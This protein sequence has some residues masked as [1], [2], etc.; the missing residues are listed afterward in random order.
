VRKSVFYPG[1][2]FF[3]PLL[4]VVLILFTQCTVVTHV[5]RLSRFQNSRYT[6]AEE[7]VQGRLEYI[8]SYPVVHIYGTPEEMGRQYG[9]LLKPQLQSL[10][11]LVE[12]VFSEEELE[13]YLQLA[14]ATEP[15]LPEE[16]RTEIRA[17]AHV[18]GISYNHLVA[19]NVATKVACSTLAT[20]GESTPEGHLIMGRNA[21]YRSKGMNKYLGLLVV[22]HP[23]NGFKSIHIT[24]LGLVGG[25]SGMNSTGL[26]YGN[27]IS[28]NSKDD[29]VNIQGLPVQLAMRLAGETTSTADE[30]AAF[31]L[32]RNLMVPNIVMVADAEKAVITEH[33]PF[34]GERREG[35]KGTL[36]S[37]NFFHTK[38]LS[39]EYKPDKRYSILQ[40]EVN[41]HYGN[42]T[43]DRMKSVMY[44]I[45]GRKRRNLQ[46][47]IME[48]S[49]M[50]L[51]ISINKIPASK[52]P[53]KEFDA[54][55]LFRD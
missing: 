14:A 42:F 47:V 31:M 28:Y 8:A 40:N 46:C 21:D 17:I 52:G 18:S 49:R 24:Y 35:E 16:I 26:S 54:M 6:P 33:T 15:F 10:F 41:T 5:T 39:V 45:R 44:E 7:T 36:G 55:E 11:T 27:M 29:S 51:H 9:F 12:S 37:T 22:R 19:L 3:I 53:F 32:E 1:G 13:E 30:Y 48:P 23:E 38:H 34:E 2:F 20:W 4:F 43:V 25:F 50:R